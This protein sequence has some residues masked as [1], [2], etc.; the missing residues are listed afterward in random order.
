M[1]AV[2]S[3]KAFGNSS[4]YIYTASTAIATM[5]TTSGGG[6]STGNL[7]GNSAHKRTTTSDSSGLPDA[8]SHFYYK[9][10]L[11]LSSYPTCATSIAIMAILL[12]CYPLINV[13]LPG[14]IPTK[15]M[16]P[17]DGHYSLFTETIQQNVSLVRNFFSP[18]ITNYNY[19]YDP[20]F[21]WA[22]SSPVFY[23]QQIM[24]RTGVLPWTEDMQ[25][26]DA[27]RA[28]LYEVFKMLE[29]VRNHE[30]AENK[31]TL[32]QSCWHVDNVK[33]TRDEKV[34]FPEY[35]CLVLSPANLWSQ[36]I[37]NF[38]KDANLLA[39]IFQY[40]NI[41]K[42]KVSTAEMLFG[43]PMQDTGF[44]RYPL[45]SRSR[46][47]QYAITLIL[48]Q[49][50]QEYLST[51][52]EKLFQ[53][54]PP[55]S[56]SKTATDQPTSQS[57]SSSQPN[58]RVD[59]ASIT[60]IF[61]PDEFK[62]WEFMPLAIAFVLLFIY[63]YF[64][65]RK[66]EIIRS[67]LLLAVCAVITVLGSLTMSLGVCSFFGLT[68]SLQSKDVFPFLVIL[69]GL[70]NCLV[71]TK[72]VVCTQETFDVK[73]RVAKALSKE[74]WHI[75]KTLLTEITI[76]TIGCITMVPVIQKFSIFAIIGLL[77]D[78]MLQMLLFSTILAMN[79]KLPEYTTEAKHLP[80]MMLRCTMTN[81][82]A[83]PPPGGFGMLPN[84]R[85]DYRFFDKS[86]SVASLTGDVAHAPFSPMSNGGLGMFHRSQSHPKLT[87]A[88]LNSHPADLTA[89][90]GIQANNVRIP[91]RLRI[92]NFWARTR[93][94]QRAFMIWMSVWICTIVYNTGCLENLLAVESNR[95]SFAYE[96][97]Q[98][99]VKTSEQTAVSSFFSN[100][101]HAI[102]GG[103]S[104]A[105]K[106]NNGKTDSADESVRRIHKGEN[107]RKKEKNK[108]ASGNGP[109]ND[110]DAELRRLIYPDFELNYFLS[111]FHWSTIMKQYNIS[112]SGRYVT[113]L[114]TIKLT[115]AI[116][117]ESAVLLRNPQEKITQNFQWKAL[118]AALDP[119][120]F[121][122]DE[123]RESPMV[124]PGG[125]PLY[126]KSPMEFFFAIT[127]CLISIFVLSYTMVVFYRCI[128]TRNY[129]EWRSSW[130]E[131]SEMPQKTEHI[132]EGVPTKIVGHKH[133]VECLISDGSHI[134]SCCLSG[135]I[136]VWDARNGEN[137]TTIQR[138]HMQIETKR[139][140]GQVV[141]ER[142][143][144]SPIWCMS[145]FDN[146]VAVGCA[147]GR[148]ELWEMPEG[149]LKCISPG[150][151]K[152]NQGIT[153]IH[154]SGDRVIVGRLCGRLEFFR[155]ETYCKG[156]QID[157][158]FTSAYRRTHARTS[159]A[160]SIGLMHHAQIPL[161]QQQHRCLHGQ[162]PP[163][164]NKEEMKI[165]LEAAR[166]AHQQPITCMEVSNGM[167]FTGSQDHTLKVY[168]LTNANVEYSLHGH[169]GPITCLF[170]DHWQP[171]TGGSGSQ[172]GM[173]CVWDLFTGAC[174]YNIQ[175]HDGA[176]TALVCAPTYVISLGVDERICVW[177]RFQGNLLTTINILN[178]YSSLLM[179]TP[180]LLVTCKMGSLIVWDVRTGE[181]AREVKLDHANSLLCPKTLML[182]GDAVVCDY[183]NELRVVRFPIVSDKYS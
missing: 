121:S 15:I 11:F 147:N 136:K 167:V 179:L 81:S 92:V 31:R 105:G 168:S 130:Y 79:I 172:D 67:R 98:R 50:D 114:P 32:D 106:G 132:L 60:Y 120:D 12:S 73:I 69:V 183:G 25:L 58:K 107:V 24:L 149:V 119:I 152:S 182:A 143:A 66:I 129:A 131:S 62:M 63:M 171:G 151:L 26:M 180:F 85:N 135:Q 101:Q 5:A 160:G 13:P 14:T 43:V 111:N 77:S 141:L 23:V 154:L 133:T 100:M 4:S 59:K 90:V 9:H 53:Y 158:N 93:F 176:V 84:G 6:G 54:Y 169:C 115:H 56:L 118:A 39:T 150:E 142:V 138:E 35:N 109:V 125:T 175:A 97:S 126:P 83:T 177:E 38:T 46:I 153:H 113:L 102:H 181:P 48:N 21:P 41:Q 2:D 71:I 174:M 57:A 155:L 61:Y 42:T 45:R 29:I 68:I 163:P 89:K 34:L 27:F 36:D 146:L 164:S 20:P 96:E 140:G 178:A 123:R 127:M 173:L 157:W 30:S 16:L 116:G 37:Q 86:V 33:R 137:L 28:P 144:Y 108:G 78:F 22:K 72:S 99:F 74:G 82:T 103:P 47:I 40:H 159:S 148:V 65:V 3:S 64:S 161:Q 55:L 19:S 104:T 88:D 1:P 17:F 145:A 52:K 112:L 94:F 8:V 156:Q 117:P 165:T 162:S 87:F 128:C 51:L 170:V 122:D 166:Y 76:L 95:T 75:S 10:G 18:P 70:E 80:K 110:T 134:I 139:E 7:G 44:K 91:K 124:F 49:N